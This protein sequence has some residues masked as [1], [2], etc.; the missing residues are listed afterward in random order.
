MKSLQDSLGL[1]GSL[2]VTS[3]DASL[4]LQDIYASA[5]QSP[6]CKEA[7]IEARRIYGHRDVFAITQYRTLAFLLGFRFRPCTYP[8]GLELRQ[9]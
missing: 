6:E 9:K 8:A 2:L 5:E 3:Q 1:V 4:T 7:G